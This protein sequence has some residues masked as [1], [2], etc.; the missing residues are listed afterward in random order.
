MSGDV[1]SD[2]C[3]YCNTRQIG[4]ADADGFYRCHDCNFFVREDWLVPE[5]DRYVLDDSR[6][7]LCPWCGYPAGVAQELTPDTEAIC[8]GCSGTIV[9]EMLVTQAA[10]VV[11]RQRG[12]KERNL[13][14]V[15]LTAIVLLMLVLGMLLAI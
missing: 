6:D 5:G 7:V 4:A 1:V 12:A 13:F 11:D 2:C 9:P 8:E 15:V 10:L 3:P 14:L